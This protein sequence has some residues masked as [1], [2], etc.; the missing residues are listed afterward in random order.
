MRLLSYI[1]L[2][3]SLSLVLAESAS[4]GTPSVGSTTRAPADDGAIN[5]VAQKLCHA[6]PVIGTRIAFKHKCDTP[7]NWRSIAN[8]HAKYSTLQASPL[9]DGNGYGPD[10]QPLSC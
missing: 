10:D 4:A 7:S 9:R 5:I 3:V 8:R 6:E 1:A 2:T